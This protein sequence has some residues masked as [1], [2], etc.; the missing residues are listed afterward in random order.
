M[1]MYLD[2]QRPIVY[3]SIAGVPKKRYSGETLGPYKLLK[4]AGEGPNADVT[5]WKAECLV[6]NAIVTVCTKRVA[7][8]I[9]QKGCKCCKGVMV[10]AQP[11]TS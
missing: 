7:T 11:S 10:E 3:R 4:V 5:Y 1:S 8:L 6:C 2:D 9:K